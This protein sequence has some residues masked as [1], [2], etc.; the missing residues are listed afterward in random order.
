LSRDKWK[1]QY[2]FNKHVIGENDK[3]VYQYN[4]VAAKPGRHVSSR[5]CRPNMTNLWLFRA[6]QPRVG[7]L[8]AW[9]LLP[10]PQS[11]QTSYRHH[12]HLISKSH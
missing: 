12:V 5:L 1:P 8:Q 9:V 4:R 3:K 6:L 2:C 11:V 7:W 10:E